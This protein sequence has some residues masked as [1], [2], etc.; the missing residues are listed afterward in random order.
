[1]SPLHS[2]QAEGIGEDAGPER[3]FTLEGIK[4][5]KAGAG[6]LA[7]AAVPDSDDPGAAGTSSGS[8]GGSLSGEHDSDEDQLRCAAL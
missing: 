2:L 7:S 5:G 8:D 1:M 3:L 6:R 4:A